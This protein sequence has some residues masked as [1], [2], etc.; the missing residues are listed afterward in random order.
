MVKPERFA[1]GMPL[2]PP[3]P[4][5]PT[6][7]W[8]ARPSK[9]ARLLRVRGVGVVGVVGAEHPH[10]VVE[11]LLEL[12][13]SFLHPGRP[14]EQGAGGVPH[15]AASSRRPAWPSRGVQQSPSHSSLAGDRLKPIPCGCLRY[16]H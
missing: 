13:D 2:S 1:A 11:K 10:A 9:D 15:L 6:T 7:P 12:A 4:V 14:A 3:D 8:R 16:A 5:V